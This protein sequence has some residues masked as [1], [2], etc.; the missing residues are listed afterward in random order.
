MY[1]TFKRAFVVFCAA[2]LL[3]AFVFYIR[4]EDP[5]ANRIT[6]LTP[7]AY[8]ALIGAQ[9]E[10]DEEPFRGECRIEDTSVPYDE[11]SRTYYVAQS[12]DTAAYD[13]GLIWVN[14]A[15]KA[16]FCP[17]ELY[18]DKLSAIAAGHAFRLIV[19]NGSTHF[20]VNLIFT[21]LPIVAL[22]RNGLTHQVDRPDYTA[23]E[24]SLYDPGYFA[25]GRYVVTKSVTAYRK[26]GSRLASRGFPKKSYRFTCF[27]KDGT[28]AHPSLLD[29]GSTDEWVLLA[30]YHD[31]TRL[32]DKVS[33]DLWNELCKTNPAV[34][35]PTDRMRFVELFIDG[36]YQGLYGLTFPMDAA[37]NIASMD[38]ATLFET[39]YVLDYNTPNRWK[40][41]LS[42]FP[43]NS[44]KI[45]WPKN[46]TD[47]SAWDPMERYL[48]AFATTPRA[49]AFAD[50]AKMI[51]LSN[52]I[53]HALYLQAIAAN[54]HRFR[55]NY[56]VQKSDGAFLITPY[57]LN[58][59]FG[60]ALHDHSTIN[61]GGLL[62]RNAIT[63]CMYFDMRTLI[64]SDLETVIPL[65]CA[66]W[67]EL[68]KTLFS[69]ES[70]KNAFAEQNAVL[71]KSG[72]LMR[73]SARWPQ[74]PISG[75]LTAIDLFV[76]LRASYMDEY[77]RAL[78]ARVS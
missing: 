60:Y 76:D 30:L 32:R 33:L 73:E 5:S 48:D 8:D 22:K 50:L 65:L 3:F 15:R 70:L 42:Y 40:Q 68:S 61:R 37:E 2:A 41:D 78:T 7:E 31:S 21:G 56:Y 13:G 27:N 29:L 14:P 52:S 9:T 39:T 47:E 36:G 1:R 75:D 38:C 43:N 62:F 46:V 34:D 20:Y 12:M 64:E 6:Q 25:A 54:D 55:N 71:T 72:A 24:F 10:T 18:A 17:D 69:A 63:D 74:I 53:D 11:K 35:I 58:A 57:D 16:Y 77:M 19:T 23:A 67:D 45:K 49:A 66:R 4:Q 28:R 51:D 44:A 59:T 26:R